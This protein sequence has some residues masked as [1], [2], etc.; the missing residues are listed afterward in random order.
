ME[1]HS[2]ERILSNQSTFK[3]LEPKCIELIAGC[4]THRTFAEGEFILKEGEDAS[5][6]FVVK[7]GRVAIEVYTGNKGSLKIQ[8]LSDRDLLG[9]SWLFPPYK[10]QF[11]ALA[12]TTVNTIMFEASCIREKCAKD[13]RFGYLILH[14][15][16]EVV[17]DRL[18]NTRLQLIDIYK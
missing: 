5:K 4:A 7:K 12:L 17:V 2:I 8:T 16:T 18:R 15:I 1:T 14:R 9:W 3:N 13:Y 10:N 6:F 11:D